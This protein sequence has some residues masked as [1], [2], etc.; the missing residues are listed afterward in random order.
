LKSKRALPGRNRGAALAMVLLLAAALIGAFLI[1][2][3]GFIAT[4]KLDSK[5]YDRAAF[6]VIDDAL[7]RFVQLNKRLPCP[8]NGASGTSTDGVEDPSSGATDCPTP[9][10]PVPWTTLGLH[11]SAATDSFGRLYS[12]RVYD[13]STGFT[14]TN[15]LDLTNCLDQDDADVVALSGSVCNA[16]THEN[17]RSDFFSGKGLT[18]DD[19]GTTKSQIAYVL[20]SHGATGYG[21]YLP[22]PSVTMTAPTSGG[23]EAINASDSATYWILDVNDTSV[24]PDNVN[25][26]DDVV[27]YR[28]VNDLVAAAKLGGRPWPISA[29]LDTANVGPYVANNK[30]SSTATAASTTGNAMTITASASSARSIC[31]V[32]TTDDAI[33]PCSFLSFSGTDR[34]TTSG[35]ERL[36]FEFRVARRFLRVKLTHFRVTGTNYEKAKFTFYNGATQV[37]EVVKSACDTNVSEADASGRFLIDPGAEFTKVEVRADDSS[38]TTDFAISSI[39]GC[40]LSDTVY[41][42]LRESGG[43]TCT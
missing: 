1:F 30:L 16:T 38:T 20:L 43:T 33:A 12:Y 15:G 3:G 8:A 17:A 22:D 19:R 9:V 31:K 25:H 36:T 39:S 29:R 21:A 10:G 41:C 14:R 5:A 24:T 32:T 28:N 40:K 23:K 42:T 4:K 27:S 11:R 7:V 18:V 13:G 35:D 37:Y 2:G 34:L 26:F 6:A